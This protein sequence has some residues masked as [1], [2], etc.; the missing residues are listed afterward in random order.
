MF[1]YEWLN[2]VYW[3]LAVE[4]LFYLTIGLIF[5]FITSKKRYVRYI[6]FVSVT[7]MAA[8]LIY[9][10]SIAIET[11]FTFVFLFS[12]LSGIVLYHYKTRI[13]SDWREFVW[14]LVVFALIK[15]LFLVWVGNLH[16]NNI[17][18]IMYLSGILIASVGI[19]TTIGILKIKKEN[20]VLFFLGKIS[21]SLYLTHYFISAF[22]TDSLHARG[23]TDNN[24]ARVISCFFILGVCILFA[25]L[26]YRLIEKLSQIWASYIKYSRNQKAHSD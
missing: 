22:L 16:L 26:F 24:I 19:F 4:V 11:K 21:Y 13:I 8:F 20:K 2:P 17:T 25:Y 5:R 10:L 7:V 1:G 3:S 23:I 18:F 6:V 15:F 9:Q 12:F 14:L